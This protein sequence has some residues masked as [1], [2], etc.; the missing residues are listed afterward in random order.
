MKHNILFISSWYPTRINP[1]LGNFI[2][3]HAECASIENNVRALHVILDA[4]SK[5]KI[6]YET[7]SQPFNSTVIYLRP[8]KIPIFGKFFNYLRIIRI[9]IRELKKMKKNGFKPDLVHANIAYPIGFVAWIYKVLFKLNFVIEEHWTG[10]HDYANVKISWLKRKIICFVSN[11][12]L[13]ILP[14]SEDLGFAIKKFGVKTPFLALPNVADVE[15]FKPTEAKNDENTIKIVHV[16]TLIDKHKNISMLLDA[17]AKTLEKHPNIE[18]HIVTD[19]DINFYNNQ[20]DDLGIKNKIINH[21]CLGVEGVSQVMK[22]CDFF[23]L[24]SNYENLPCVLIESILCGTPVVS[25]N[26]GGVSEIIND[27]NGI[28]VPSKDLNALVLAIETMINKYKTYDKQ[29]MHEDAV[30][31]YSYQAIA[32]LLSDIYGKYVK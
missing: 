24:T 10:Y 11:K 27:E 13:L 19:G 21:G 3:K 32:K 26:V 31:K 22:N 29:K 14:V 8:Y 7:E 5:K 23:V 12:A 30:K 9:Y 6:E 4:S 25:T 17:F 18:L 16:S 1:T 2:F 15:L 20:I 28:L